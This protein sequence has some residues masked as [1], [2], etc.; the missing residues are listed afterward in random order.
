MKKFLLKWLTSKWCK[1]LLKAAVVIY[2]DEQ[3]DDK[4]SKI[5]RKQVQAIKALM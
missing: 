5:T 4:G 2:L 3:A 1:R